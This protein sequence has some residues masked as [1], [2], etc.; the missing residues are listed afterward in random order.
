[1]WLNKQADAVDNENRTPFPI[2][3][4][5]QYSIVP[6]CCLLFPKL[7]Q[8]ISLKTSANQPAK[9]CIGSIAGH[10]KGISSFFRDVVLF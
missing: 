2:M 8:H 7:C 3:C 10:D 5:A 6:R 1:M 9:H 4:M